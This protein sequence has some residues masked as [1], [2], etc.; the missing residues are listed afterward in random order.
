MDIPR[1]NVSVP[2]VAGLDFC[3]RARLIALLDE[4][5]QAGDAAAVTA[6][7]KRG[8]IELMRSGDLELPPVCRETCADHYRRRELYR[9]ERYGYS[10]IAMSWAPSQGTGVH[11]H[12]GLWC[13][14]G[15]CAGCLQ[16]QQYDLGARDG[17][18]YRL[19][20][21]DDHI[22]RT[23]SAGALIPP[24]E[25]HRIVNT[26]AAESA[27]SLHVYERAMTTCNVFEPL[28]EGW[29]RRSARQLV[30]DS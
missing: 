28:G 9:S 13:V 1:S 11:D 15:V 4:A 7:I 12:A 18:R 30:L 5:V 16:V 2:A 22:A 20:H 27:V 23:G 19:E 26:S 21:R 3:G 14:E 8:L 10:V 17:E 24:F 29:F 6:A 25:Y